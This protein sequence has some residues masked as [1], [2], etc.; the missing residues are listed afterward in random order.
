MTR[1]AR[2]VA[3]VGLALLAAG[4]LA[5]QPAEPS[6][7]EKL[8][9][10]LVQR[11]E[12]AVQR[13]LDPRFRAAVVR[14]LVA[15]DDE[16]LAARAAA[17]PGLG[18]LALG[19]SGSQLVYTKVE[20]CRLIDTRIAGGSLA[21]GVARDFRAT[22]AGLQGQGGSVAG[23]NV[24]FGTATAAA[25]NFVAVNP[26]GPGNLRAWAYDT[27]PP[28]PPAAS[29]LN[30][31]S[32]PGF[33]I[34]N[35]LIVPLCTGTPVDCPFD[36]RV[37][38]DGSGTQ[39]VADV[40]GY[41][42]RFPTEQVRSF[43]VPGSAS[44]NADI[45]SACANVASAQVV[46]A[47]PGPGRVVV[48]ANVR[49][50]LGHIGPSP[51]TMMLVINTSPTVCPPSSLSRVGLPAGAADGT[52]VYTVPVWATFP[53][54]ASGSFTYYVNAMMEPGSATGDDS[55]IVPLIEATFHPN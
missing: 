54:P 22:G 5:S 43:T 47:A 50:G 3:F 32:I 13:T 11:A 36:F 48:R 24:P 46:V 42:E 19:D 1:L 6:E 37:Q 35:E 40:L 41:F 52:Y 49:V 7:K 34:A 23:C 15:L 14:A 26:V 31:Q 21:P 30:Y 45:I 33:N 20:P 16:E 17:G 8:A 2:R 27:P 12:A 10:S 9:E 28:P 18:P 53:I 44:P 4:P 51:D 39:L 55:A 29:I 25:V 38:A